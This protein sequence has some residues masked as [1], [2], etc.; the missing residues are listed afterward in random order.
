M[1]SY[2][3]PMALI[4]CSNVVYQICCKSVP[5]GLNSFASLSVTYLVGAAIS[6][7]LYFLL[8]KPGNLL[9]EYHKLNWAPFM[10]GIAIVGLEVGF[11]YAYKAGWQVSTASIVQSSFLAV[12]LIFVGW[13]LYHEAFTWNKIAG[14]FICLVGLAVI[15]LK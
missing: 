5:D 2:V 6:I 13:T 15:R 12:L 7:L 3:W 1:F 4:V 8:K 10:L 9:Q 14:V 11:I